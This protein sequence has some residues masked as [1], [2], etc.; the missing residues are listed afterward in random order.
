MSLKIARID[1]IAFLRPAD[2]L[3]PWLQFRLR[4]WKSYPLRWY[5]THRAGNIISF[6]VWKQCYEE[7][8]KQLAKL[9]EKLSLN[10]RFVEKALMFLLVVDALQDSGLP[11]P[12]C[13]ALSL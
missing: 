7:N 5:N 4:D 1:V 8:M 6:D 3:H 2:E 10:G 12:E 9:R 11:K 13:M